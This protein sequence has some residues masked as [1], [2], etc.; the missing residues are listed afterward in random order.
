[1]R[2]K[3]LAVSLAA[4]AAML[5]F[6]KPAD[7]ETTLRLSTGVDYSSGKYGGTQKTDVIVAPFSAKV[8][9]GSWALR[10][11]VPVISIKGPAS[12]VVIE[13]A[14]GST[15]GSTPGGSG[16][17][18]EVTSGTAT[19]R[20]TTTGV[21]DLSLSGSYT[22]D[23]LL[24]ADSYLELGGRV[25]LPTGDE[26]KGLS[27]GVTDYAT[28]AEL[29]VAR[30]HSGAYVLGGRRFNKDAKGID[31][32]DGWQAEVGGWLRAS[33]STV[34]GGS[35]DWRESSVRGGKDVSEASA[36]VSY[37]LTEAVRVGATASAG[38]TDGAADYGVGLNLSW[39]TDLFR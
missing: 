25:R 14:G 34:V 36:Y 19:T 30:K 13:D 22:F 6:A 28:T 15:S 37:K 23:D 5:G 2:F 26:A 11:T 1:M 39:K 38:L 35:V 33:E 24:G 29:G 17:S 16:S 4:L 18:G 31:R 20:K 21:G 8:S 10:A 27:L 9:S 7:A 32:V 12:F 3:N